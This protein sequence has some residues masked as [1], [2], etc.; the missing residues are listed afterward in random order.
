MKFLLL[1]CMF[2]FVISTYSLAS[3]KNDVDKIYTVPAAKTE[4]MIGRDVP[5]QTQNA[6][7]RSRN[8][9][10]AGITRGS[11]TYKLP[12]L[13]N[14]PADFSPALIGIS[15]GRKAANEIYFLKGYFELNGEW[16]SFKRELGVFSQKLNVFQ[17]S[18]IQNVDLAW[19]IKK[20]LFFSG[21]IGLTPVYLTAE[22]SVF[23]NSISHLGAMALLK[24]NVIFPVQQKY[25]YD[26]GLKFGWGNV[27]GIEIFIS[28]LSLG[29]NFE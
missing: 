21:G 5:I 2:S 28:T 19:S 29:I 24:F 18:I 3:E 9:F 7:A 22:Q 12:A 13:N 1:L 20:A 14:A 10:Y 8:L 27:G 11:L 26:L 17:L 4:I 6:D 15:L 16:Q 23:G 25:E